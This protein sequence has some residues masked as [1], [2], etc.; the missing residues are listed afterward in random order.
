MKLVTFEINGKERIGALL[1]DEIVDLKLTYMANFGED[2]NLKIFEDMISYIEYIESGL[3]PGK[4]ILNV[5]KTNS[6]R[7]VL[8][9]LSEVKL[10]APVP[11]PR[12]VLC[13]AGNYAEHIRE[14]RGDV[15]SREVLDKTTTVPRVFMKPPSTTVIGPYDTVV[16]P[17]NGQQ[18]DWEAELAV[19]IGKRGKFISAKDAPNYIA[20]YTVMNDTS[21]RKL[22]VS[23]TRVPREGDKWFDWLN[24]KWFDTF[25]PQGPC[26]VTEDEVGDPNNLK[27]SLRVNGEIMQNSNTKNMIFNTYDLVEFISTIVTLEPGDLISTGTPEGV[28]IARGILL[29]DGDLM[30]TEVENIGTMRNPIKVQS[31]S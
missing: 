31:G 16:I 8:Y 21:E 18:I 7:A 14:G 19:V 6:K 27:I 9:S 29:K 10:K 13:L 20:G 24:G 11:R 5:A 23:P 30:E 12:K 15:I 3:H 4:E 28:G 1:G 25:A 17:K 22:K 26:L 2:G